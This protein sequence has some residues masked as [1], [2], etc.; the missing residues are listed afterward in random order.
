MH[1]LT[2]RHILEPHW[3]AMLAHTSSQA[4]HWHALGDLDQFCRLSRY[5]WSYALDL[6]NYRE[7]LSAQPPRTLSGS[8]N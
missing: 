2:L 7:D 1:S 6:T 3:R 8:R 4:I 5:A